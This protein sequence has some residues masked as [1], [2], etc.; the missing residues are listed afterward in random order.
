MTS[1]IRCPYCNKELVCLNEYELSDI[2]HNDYTHILHNDYTH[3]RNYW[4]DKCNVDITIAFVKN[5]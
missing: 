5:K 4:C 2:L 3:E 1:K